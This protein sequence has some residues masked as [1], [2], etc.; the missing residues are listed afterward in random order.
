MFQ[1]SAILQQADLRR[2]KRF[3]VSSRT[4]LGYGVALC[5]GLFVFALVLVGSFAFA[6]PVPWLD[7]LN[8]GV[9]ALGVGATYALLAVPPADR[10]LHAS[11]KRLLGLVQ[12]PLSWFIAIALV[13]LAAVALSGTFASPSRSAWGWLLVGALL[14]TVVR[15]LLHGRLAAMMN[16]GQLQ[17]DRTALVGDG[18]AL[19]RFEREARIWKQGGQVVARHALGETNRTTNAALQDF[20]A[21]CAERR[22]DN[23]LLVGHLGTFVAAGA[24]IEACRPYAINVAFAP[25]MEHGDELQKLHDVLHIGPA[26]AVRVMRKPLSDGAIAAK[27]LLDILGAGLGLLITA[28]LLLAV[29][30]AIRLSGPGPIFYRQERMGFN[31]RPFYILKFRSMRVSEDGRAMR[32]AVAGD[33]RITPLGRLMRRSSIDELPQLLNVVRG[34]MSLVGP[35]P[36]AISHDAELSRG[37]SLYARRQRIKP[38]ITGWAQVNGYRGEIATQAQLEGRTLHDLDYV[39]NWSMWFDL[40]ILWLTMFS[41]KVHHNA[42]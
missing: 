11:G 12:A 14:T 15:W 9:A 25:I 42:G 3:R 2:Y 21:L 31:G 7:T 32:P 13:W 27:R 26:N 36:H 10:L 23:V 40:K 1:D 37:F 18:E 8:A 6:T 39:E 16:N 41:R 30:T 38:G 17:V 35:R 4:Y 19:R 29:S 22:C 5:E 33:E 20:A 34:D 28:P 24:V